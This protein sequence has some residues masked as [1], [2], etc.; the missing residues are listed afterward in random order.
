MN[1]LRWRGRGLIFVK[2]GAALSYEYLFHILVERFVQSR[3]SPASASWRG[4]TA[5]RTR[6]RGGAGVPARARATRS[7][8]VELT[9][10]DL[11]RML[12]RAAYLRALAARNR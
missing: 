4:R 12:A 5:A 11:E 3:K 2:P 10:E 7:M 8:H 6:S 1:D 9:K